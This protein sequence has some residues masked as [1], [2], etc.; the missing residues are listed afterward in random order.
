M[1]NAQW[2][3]GAANVGLAVTCIGV[4]LATGGMGAQAAE[5]L[6]LRYSMAGAM[7]TLRG[8]VFV[9]MSSALIASSS[10]QSFQI[11]IGVRRNYSIGDDLYAMAIGGGLPVALRGLQAGWGSLCNLLR[12]PVVTARGIVNGRTFVDVNQSARWGANSNSPTLIAD[13]VAAREA[14]RGRAFPNGNMATAH[15]EIGV[16]QQAYNAGQTTGMEMYMSVEGRRICGYCMG[17]IASMGQQA[18]LTSIRVFEY[19]T[20]RM[21]FWNSGMRSPRVLG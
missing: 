5:S 13:T 9:G 11:A 8:Q 10:V 19:E 12:R 4:A 6:V 15:A 17:D 3:G 21:F 16:I 7:A 14:A 18:G 2:W 1:G 20:G